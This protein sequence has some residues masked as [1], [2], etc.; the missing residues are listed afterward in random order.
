MSDETTSDDVKYF[1]EIAVDKEKI[2]H[3]KAFRVQ[4][5]CI[6]FI[7]KEQSW[8]VTEDN[9]RKILSEREEV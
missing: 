2:E 7:R 3:S 8:K 4:T 5:E 6:N 9:I 1:S